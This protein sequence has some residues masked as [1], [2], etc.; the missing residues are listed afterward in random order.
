M[1]EAQGIAANYM[2]DTDG[3]NPATLSGQGP[4]QITWNTPGVKDITLI[5]EEHTCISPQE[6]QSVTVFPVPTSDFTIA[7]SVC[8]GEIVQ[9]VYSGTGTTGSFAWN[10]DGGQILSGTGIGP[11]MVQWPTS[12]TKDVCLQVEENGCISTLTCNPIK[13]LAEPNAAIDPVANQCFTGNSFNFVYSGDPSTSYSWIFG[14]DAVPAV[15]T[16][17]NPGAVNYLNPGVKT[18]TVVV[19]RSGC[20]GDT[21]SVSF[22]VVPEPSANFTASSNGLCSDDCITFTYSGTSLG[23]NQTYF[24]DFGTSAI[25]PTSS[26][27]NPPCIEFFNSGVQNISLTTSYKG[28]AVTSTQQVTIHGLPLVSAGP[29]KEFCEGDG[30]S[31]V[32]ASVSGGTA[33]YFYSWW[34]DDPTNCG[35]SKQCDRRSSYEPQQSRC[36]SCCN[37]LLHGP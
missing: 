29:D 6:T 27:P 26:Q 7:D 36:S 12:G 2:W 20:I 15:S 11:Y 34:C 4:H 30:G 9:I 22:E 10:F 16:S 37:L 23:P 17:A 3:G 8:E 21:A 32:D 18:V 5:V 14:A 1:L 31:L 33:P 13:I 28:C 24:W 19:T 35:L 25:P